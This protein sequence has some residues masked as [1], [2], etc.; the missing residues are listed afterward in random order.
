MVF[1]PNFVIQAVTP[2][3][4]AVSN[5]H[6]LPL[7]LL[8]LLDTPRPGI[9]QPADQLATPDPSSAVVELTL[10]SVEPALNLLQFRQ[11]IALVCD[12][13]TTR[14]MVVG[15][16][17]PDVATGTTTVVTEIMAP[18]DGTTARSATS[19]MERLVETVNTMGV[20]A[21]GTTVVQFG[22]QV[23]QRPASTGSSVPP[24]VD[25]E[26]DSTLTA[27]QISLMAGSS[28]CGLVRMA[29]TA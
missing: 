28:F 15:T 1:A 8:L 16:P 2:D 22:A 24:A 27:L 18:A 7:L 21:G 13:N 19:A 12:V 23:T 11:D 4:M 14:V 6:L 9:C 5:R 20:S 17:A 10:S 29:N 3:H 26:E 25:R